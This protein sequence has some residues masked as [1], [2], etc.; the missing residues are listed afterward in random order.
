MAVETEQV[1]NE[2]KDI[3]NGPGDMPQG[4]TLTHAQRTA[5]NSALLI[6]QPL[7]L[8]IVS[9]FVT[10]YI[11]RTLGM[12]DYGR[13]TFAIAFVG[14]FLPFINVGLRTI[15]VREIAE[16]RNTLSTFLG[17]MVALRVFLAVIAI[18]TIFLGINILGY[19]QTTKNIVYIF[20][21]TILFGAISSTFIDTFQAYEKM[22][23]VAWTQFAAGAIL[24]L[25]SVV[26]LYLGY[27]LMGL[28][29]IYTFGSFLTLVF[30]FWYL[31]RKFTVPKIA[32]DLRF[33][34][35]NLHKGAPFF[36]PALV[37]TI[38]GRMGIIILSKIAGDASVGIYGAASM[39]VDRLMVIP[40]GI[41]TAIF[42]TM[43]HLH[44][45]SKEE[46]VSI[47][48]RF[49][50]YLVLLGLPIA[51]GITILAG[52]IINLMYG[53]EY[54]SATPVLQFLAWWLFFSFLTYIQS[55]ALGAIHREK[56]AAKIRLGTAIFGV[57]LN[58]IFIIWLGV[59][60]LAISSVAT[61]L[62]Y[63][64]LLSRPIKKYLVKDLL[65]L[66]IFVKIIVANMVMAIFVALTL[67][68]NVFLPIAAGAVSYASIIVFLGVARHAELN[69]LVKSIIKR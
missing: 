34:K 54:K 46:A 52:P 68:Y 7:I 22:E 26:V 41:G 55:L 9:I 61:A 24:T 8:N 29:L 19:P 53:A 51:L 69:K 23:Y 47:F 37:A 57:V 43:A 15:T 20:S 14:M 36:Y 62:I 64:A 30:A 18:V 49:F 32:V 56:E 13:F 48:R 2:Y 50:L 6:I 31:S 28:M 35:E 44:K 33:W 17:R 38:G 65:N 12:G 66:K 27:R 25:L 11:A 10:A 42:P 59:I 40:D 16:N 21:A 39:L 1:T 45:N 67:K 63:C 5:K 3:L 58:F 60:G 4:Q